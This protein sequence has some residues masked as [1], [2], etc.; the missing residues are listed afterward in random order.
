MSV[1]EL[2]LRST[3]FQPVSSCLR[4]CSYGEGKRGV[5]EWES[6]VRIPDLM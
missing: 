4:L 6:Y 5:E 2:T 3:V 1:S